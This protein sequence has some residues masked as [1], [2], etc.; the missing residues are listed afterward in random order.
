M[1]RRDQENGRQPSRKSVTLGVRGAGSSVTLAVMP[2]V[3][4][5]AA[6]RSLL[7]EEHALIAAAR[8]AAFVRYEGV[9]VPHRSCGIALAETFG[10]P[11]RAYQALRRGGI[12]GAGFCGALRAGEHILGEL[13]G[14]PDPAGAV[15]P[16]LRAAITW[17]GERVRERMAA[18]DYSCHALT[19]PHGDFA[20]N[21]RKGMCSNIAALAAE[22]TAE[23]LVRFLPEGRPVVVPVAP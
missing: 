7:P 5:S 11:T 4:L 9:Q 6:T 22:L 2:D 23:A 19:A 8:A 3:S 13:L 10:V 17:Y 21:A 14:D 18:P 12:T 15:T 16:A 1:A 20:S